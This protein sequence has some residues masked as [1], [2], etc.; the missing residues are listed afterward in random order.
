[1]DTTFFDE[2]GKV[3]SDKGKEAA[4]KAREVTDL[5][6][7]KAQVSSE[8]AKARERYAAMG[9]AFYEQQ[10]EEAK[11]QFPSLFDEVQTI[12][13][14]ITVLEERIRELEKT[15]ICPVCKA[16]VDRDAIFCS[17][18]GAS[19]KEAAEEEAVVSESLFIEEVEEV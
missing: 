13:D 4:Q 10:P 19:L 6:Q 8:R 17:K 9:K 11:T 1:M 14:G 7:L 12:L 18:C 15:K 16:V 2:L 3:I 5:L